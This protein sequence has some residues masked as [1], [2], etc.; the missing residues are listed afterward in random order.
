MLNCL[1]NVA[2]N[3]AVQQALWIVAQ[4]VNKVLPTNSCENKP[5]SQREFV[6][7][8]SQ[9][10]YIVVTVESPR[11]QTFVFTLSSML[12]ITVRDICNYEVT[13]FFSGLILASFLGIKE[14]I[15]TIFCL[16]IMHTS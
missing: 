9:C 5:K 15:S 13:F 11:F 4:N 16:F 6:F 8:H 12:Q 10:K 2:L 14:N 7:T 1:L 3:V